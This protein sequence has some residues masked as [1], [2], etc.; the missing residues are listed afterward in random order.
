M[1]S[2]AVKVV[3]ERGAIRILKHITMRRNRKMDC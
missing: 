2:L 1:R 3:D